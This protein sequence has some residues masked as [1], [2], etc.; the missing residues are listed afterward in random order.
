MV[1]ENTLI[2]KEFTIKG[3]SKTI[4]KTAMA[5]KTMQMDHITL[6]LMQK[7]KNMEMVHLLGA[8]DLHILGLF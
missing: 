1:P 4:L 7:V 2:S 3:N 8:M 5:K 6:G